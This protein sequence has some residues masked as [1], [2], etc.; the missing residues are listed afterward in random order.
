MTYLNMS[1]FK[2]H[3]WITLSTES[4]STLAKLV[5]KPFSFERCLVFSCS[6][7]TD[8]CKARDWEQEG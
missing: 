1:S 8:H 2:G 3:D 5:L 4:D 6:M 7:L